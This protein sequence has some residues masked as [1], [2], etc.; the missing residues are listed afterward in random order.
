VEETHTRQFGGTGLGLSI[1]KAFIEMIGGK[2][3]V[4]SSKGKGTT[5]FITLP[6]KNQ[7]KKEKNQTNTKQERI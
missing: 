3:W 5:F 6:G 7:E 2:I 1:S 4:K